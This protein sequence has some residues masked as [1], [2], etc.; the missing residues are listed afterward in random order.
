MDQIRRL[1]TS[2][3][4]ASDKVDNEPHVGGGQLFQLREVSG[5]GHGLVA[6]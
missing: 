3:N 1:T 4:M 5:K 6:N 2:T